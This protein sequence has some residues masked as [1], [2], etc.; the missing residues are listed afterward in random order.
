MSGIAALKG[1]RTQF[2]YS[3]YLILSENKKNRTY[4]LEGIEDIDIYDENSNL[5]ELLQV[6]NLTKQITLSDLLSKTKT[7]FFRR[8]LSVQCKKANIKPIIVSFGSFS[9]ELLSW[10]EA[11]NSITKN[12]RKAIQ[13]YEL[14]ENEW[15]IIKRNIQVV[16]INEVDI[17]NSIL[18][19]LK[20]KYP[21][22]DPIPTIKILVYWLSFNAEKQR[23]VTTDKLF[24]E[25]QKI[26]IFLAE[27]IAVTNQLGIFISPINESL[28]E[29]LDPN[30]LIE[31]YYSGISAR[32][33][34]ILANLD[35]VRNDFL[36]IV[37]NGF[38][39]HNVI[40]LRGAS[41]Q[42]KS[43]LA[44]RYIQDYCP[45]NFVY[46]ITLQEDFI[47]T[48][49]AIT[50]IRGLS[51][52]LSISVLF[53]INVQPN[54][55]EWLKIVREFS[56]DKQINFLITVRQEDWYKAIA[57]G[58][59]FRLKEIEVSLTKQEARNIYS[60]INEKHID[61]A[62]TDFDEAWI[63]FGESGPLLEFVYSITKGESLTAKLHQQVSIL[64]NENLSA[65]NEILNVLRVIVLI[66]AYGGR[67]DVR[68]IRGVNNIL[69]ITKRLEKEYLIKIDTEEKYLTG[70][71]PLRSKLLLNHLYDEVIICKKD[72]ISQCLSYIVDNDV[73]YFL[74]N[75]LND[76]IVTAG[77]VVAEITQINNSWLFYSSL[78]DAFNWL[79]VC[80]YI[81]ANRSFID[82][83][84]SQWGGA[85]YM[86]V[87]VYFGDTFSTKEFLDGIDFLQKDAGEK[88]TA[89]NQQLVPK[90]SVFKYAEN[91]MKNVCLPQ[92]I[93]S[94]KEDWT[95]YGKVLFWLKQIPNSHEDIKAIDAEYINSSVRYL[96]AEAIADVLLGM[97]FHMEIFSVNIN[98]LQEDFIKKMQVE[99][100]IPFIAIEDDKIS[101][102]YISDI[103]QHE[104]NF[105]RN[106]YTVAIIDL[107]RKA[108]PNKQ[109]YSVQGL[110]HNISL[111]PLP[112]DDSFKNI[113][114]KNLPLSQWVN[115]N[116]IAIRRYDYQNMPRD[117]QSF[118][119]ILEKWEQSISQHVLF[120]NQ[121][122]SKFRKDRTNLKSLLDLATNAQYNSLEMLMKPQSISDPLGIYYNEREEK[123]KTLGKEQVAIRK[124]ETKFDTFFKNHSKYR[125]GI[126]NFIRQ[127][128]ETILNRLKAVIEKNDDTNSNTE[129]ISQVNLFEAI[130]NINSYLSKKD[131][132]FHK[133]SVDNAINIKQNDLFRTAFYWKEYLNNAQHSVSRY[134]PNNYIEELKLD[135]E[136][137]LIHNCKKESQKGWFSLKYQNDRLTNYKPIII[138]KALEPVYVLLGVKAAFK[139]IQEAINKPEY[140]SIKQLMINSNFKD[141]FIVPL[142]HDYTMNSCW[143]SIRE[144]VFRDEYDNIGVHNWVP[145]PIDESIIKN[146][147]LVDW[148]IL[149]PQIVKAKAFIERFMLTPIYLQHIVELKFFE[150]NELNE[151]G[152]TIFVDHVM[153]IHGELQKELQSTLDYLADVLEEFP[154]DENL[155]Q[156]DEFES[157]YWNALMAIKNNLF[158]TEKGDEIEYSVKLQF[159]DLEIW[160]KKLAICVEH[161]TMF[162]FLLSGKYINR[163][164]NS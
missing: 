50:A 103:T 58:I 123:K 23:I 155:Y 105:S 84:R 22:T 147:K 150:T 92:N 122:F 42:G 90:S 109:K 55:V 27:T 3:L 32:Y 81:E 8:Y 75:V 45:S 138:I 53:L 68:K 34:H 59:E 13:A 96:D 5:I 61:F 7:S 124:F 130:E 57:Y 107:F 91:F 77:E 139:A 157:E 133:F 14:T 63:R 87:D 102:R 113:S 71:H 52:E 78:L 140:V 89:I 135:F 98:M 36:D 33:E 162:Y 69:G 100:N 101:A 104:E 66:D 6:K 2:L 106:E 43:T 37:V 49:S 47:N 67:V 132:Q 24:S 126:E 26:A 70:L 159:D 12:E 4:F 56:N 154:F 118:Y 39:E 119:N 149:A 1:Y 85:W 72:F 62:N 121:I 144:Y 137:R 158:P 10:I 97:S 99:Y 110:G 136:K 76:R 160:S 21:F 60:K 94:T 31:E 143:Y 115:L 18:E 83:A 88:S 17:Y 65:P 46:E 64:E 54:S 28:L 142:V 80:D 108:F 9:S 86:M 112:Y 74:V 82:D 29:N 146:L 148:T 153:K 116:A 129:H 161:I 111:I 127:S 35:V 16:L 120:F 11:K 48:R 93:P 114:I 131:M 40:V 152:Q 145:Q 95:G 156:S 164:L 73:F 117:W 38:E 134:N 30:S 151:L 163:S 25:I 41:G 20:D 128:S 51:K 79:G 44:Y 125:N 15:Y 141:F 19:L